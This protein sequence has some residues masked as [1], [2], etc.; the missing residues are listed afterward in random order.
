MKLPS[1][2]QVLS[3]A[4]RSLKRFPLV[5]LVAVVATIASIVLLDA[6]DMHRRLFLHN[7]IYACVPGFPFLLAI[8]VAAEKASMGRGKSLLLQ[9]VALLA[10]AVYAVTLPGNLPFAPDM[11]G[12]RLALLIMGM[13]FLLAF[14]PWL[15]AGEVNGFWQFNRRLAMRCVIAG[16]YTGV[17]FAGLAIALAALDNLFGIDVP[18]KR[19][20]ELWLLLIGVFATWFLLAGVPE[21]LS[22]LEGDD[23][24]PKGLKVFAQ[25]IVLPLAIVYLVILYAY[26]AKI[27]IG[28]EW[29]RG[30]VSK[31]VLGFAATGTFTLLLLHPVRELAGNVWIRRAS[32]WYHIVLIPLVVML[33]LAVWRRVS[34]YGMTEGRYMALLLGVWCAAMIV[35][36]LASRGRSIKAIPITLCVL[37]FLASFGP[38]GAF[39]V[40]ERSQTG[41]LETLLARNKILAGGKVTKAA[42][43]VP[44]IDAREISSILLYLRSMYGYDGIQPWFAES[45][46][47][48]TAAEDGEF[49]EP[50]DVASLLGV[51]Y[52]SGWADDD[53]VDISFESSDDAA[54]SVAGYDR[55]LS[56][57]WF[58][59]EM[60]THEFPAAGLSLRAS[61]DLATL[62]VTFLSD[63]ARVDS[64]R[65]DMRALAARMN[66]AYARK[67]MRAIPPDSMAVTA[68][69]PHAEVKVIVPMMSVH[70]DKGKIEVVNFRAAVLYRA[71]KDTASLR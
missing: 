11:H 23:S 12:V 60:R 55:L 4:G 25:Y 39:S 38:W 70:R 50:E 54:M 52:V 35:Y 43:A 22:A 19:Y 9:G 6:E 64:V 40:S 48:E 33:F 10:L 71:A 15:R 13:I 24:Y 59:K 42:R 44:D 14:L 5:L 47:R 30:W 27:L 17:L 53:D 61:A 37:A 2:H 63:S 28:W 32:R 68:S 21:D 18:G 26:M 3:E 20:G 65:V 36:F 41:R 58:S 29:P 57:R 49:K 51:E 46:R 66:A 69:C 67:N 31:L 56:G 34:E 16:L 62:T 8:A 7:I 45:L 1:V